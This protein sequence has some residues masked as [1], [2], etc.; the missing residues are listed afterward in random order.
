VKLEKR[1]IKKT[2]E[3]KKK[4]IQEPQKQKH[5][6]IARN[7][8]T[9]WLAGCYYIYPTTTTTTAT[10]THDSYKETG[11]YITTHTHILYARDLYSL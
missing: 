11:V 10:T 4:N 8:C 9:S 7:L 1:K 3:R 2:R 6:E 5:K